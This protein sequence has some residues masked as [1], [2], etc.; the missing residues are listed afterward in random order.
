MH[1][2]SRNC[3]YKKKKNLKTKSDLRYTVTK[4]QYGLCIFLKINKYY[5]ILYRTMFKIIQVL[6]NNKICD[7]KMSINYNYFQ[8]LCFIRSH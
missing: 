4:L 2:S 6:M 1:I 7:S 8:E 3:T 5:N